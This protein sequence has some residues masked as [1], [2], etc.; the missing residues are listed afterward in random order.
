MIANEGPK[1]WQTKGKFDQ[2]FR[3]SIRPD[4]RK[5]NDFK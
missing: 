5:N 1:F 4:A 2:I 3:D